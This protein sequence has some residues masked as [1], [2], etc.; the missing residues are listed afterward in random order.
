LVKQLGYFK[1]LGGALKRFPLVLPRRF[2]EFQ[3]AKLS[4]KEIFQKFI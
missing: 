3:E 1:I 2:K 4:D